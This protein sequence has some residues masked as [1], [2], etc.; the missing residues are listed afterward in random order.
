MGVFGE[1]AAVDAYA[2]AVRDVLDERHEFLELGR[3][4]SLDGVRTCGDDKIGILEGREVAGFAVEFK[5]QGSVYGFTVDGVTGQSYGS[6]ISICI[7]SQY[8]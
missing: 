6:H 7:C 5:R 4:G 1:E 8:P 3:P 2:F